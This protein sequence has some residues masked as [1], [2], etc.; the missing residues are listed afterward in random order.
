MNSG[1]YAALSGNM[2]MM[3]K[4]NVVSNNLANVNT[5]GYKKDRA[6][7]EKILDSVN[8]PTPN[9]QNGTDAPIESVVRVYTDFSTGALKQTGATFH[10]AI[11]GDGFFAV[12][13]PQGTAYTR[14]GNF[15]RNSAGKLTTIDGYEVLGKGGTPVTVTGGKVEIDSGGNIFVD[16]TKTGALEV[17]DFPKPYQLQKIGKTLFL[18]A[19]PQVV[20]QSVQKPAVAQGFVE[21]S[22]V[23]AIEEMMQLLDSSR[24]FES[25]Q[26]VVRS[27]D[28]MSG[29]AIELGKL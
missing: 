6:Y 26:K 28:D 27:Y 23:S 2:N 29:K 12:N 17:V 22:N 15:Q 18:P 3:E 4:L 8:N 10:V 5:V 24:N 13:T 1:M 14:Q 25:C 7:F 9:G 16:G 11:E 21:E 20:P 19:N